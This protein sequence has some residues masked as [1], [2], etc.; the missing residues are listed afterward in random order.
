MIGKCES[1]F[2]V[3]QESR[4]VNIVSGDRNARGKGGKG[5]KGKGVHQTISSSKVSFSNNELDF[6][7]CASLLR[8]CRAQR[9]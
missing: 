8:S 3:S 2:V 6:Q 4:N 1:V 7:S 9:R 5:G